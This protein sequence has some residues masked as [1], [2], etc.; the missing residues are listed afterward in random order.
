MNGKIRVV[1]TM[2]ID[3]SEYQGVE[4]TPEDV[5]DLVNDMLLG[6]ADLPEKYNIQ[7]G[8]KTI[9]FNY[10]QPAGKSFPILA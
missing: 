2:E 6:G 8:A 4:N 1:V 7:A 3:P 9:S 10:Y 5:I